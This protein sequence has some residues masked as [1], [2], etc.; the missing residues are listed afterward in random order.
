VQEPSAPA[1]PSYTQLLEQNAQLRE[2]VQSLTAQ[3]ASQ[4]KQILELQARLG[5]NS[6]NASKP[7]SSDALAKPP[8]PSRF[9]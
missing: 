7:P 8:P 2:L 4:Q 1:A 6:T 3:L 9:G 5:K